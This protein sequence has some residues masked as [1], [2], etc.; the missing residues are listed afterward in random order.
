MSHVC[1]SSCAHTVDVGYCHTLVEV[2]GE[3][4]PD[5]PHPD[6]VEY[7]PEFAAQAQRDAKFDVGFMRRRLSQDMPDG[8]WAL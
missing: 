5:C 6:H 7:D 4:R 1:D 3:C 2:G 8:G